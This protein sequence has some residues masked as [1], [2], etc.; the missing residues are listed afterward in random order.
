MQPQSMEHQASRPHREANG[1]GLCE[2]TLMV[3]AA[4]QDLHTD[5][6]AGTGFAGPTG[7]FAVR[8]PPEP[9]GGAR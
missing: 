7:P 4:R 6:G 8:H 3:V 2:R 5:A 1:G 9:A